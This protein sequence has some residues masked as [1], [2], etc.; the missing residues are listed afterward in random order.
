MRLILASLA[1]SSLT[2]MGQVKIRVSPQHPKKYEMVHASVENTGSNRITFCIEVGQTS[3]KEGGEIE[4]TPWPFWVQRNNNGNWNPHDWPRR[5][6][7]R[8]AKCSGRWQVGRVRFSL[9]RIW[10]NA[11]A[12]ELLEGVSR[13]LGL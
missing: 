6:P 4:S 3:P 5:R 12:N 10:A 8:V 9:G 2:A 1:L 7:F 13:K 11:T